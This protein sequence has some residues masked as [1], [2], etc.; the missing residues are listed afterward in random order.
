MSADRSGD[1]RLLV[2]A[3]RAAELLSISPRTLWSLTNAR[4]IPHIRIRRSLRYC[5]ADLEAWIEARKV[6]ERHR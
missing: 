2:N 1:G 4:Q 6:R 5:L 3:K